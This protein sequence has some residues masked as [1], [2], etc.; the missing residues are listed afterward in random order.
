MFK[1]GVRY[2]RPGPE[3][4][5]A[6]VT[7]VCEDTHHSWDAAKALAQAGTAVSIHADRIAK[8]LDERHDRQAELAAALAG[9]GDVRA[10]PHLR[11]LAKDRP[12]PTH[13]IHVGVLA[14]LPAAGLLPTMRTVLRQGPPEYHAN[15]SALELLAQ[16][17]PDSAPAVPE[18]LPYLESPHAYD[19]LRVLGR[20][21][22][23]AAVA[24]GR[25]T[26]PPVAPRRAPGTTPGWPPGRTGGSP[27]TRSSPSACAVRPRLPG[28]RATGCPSW[29]TS[30]RLPPRTR[31][32]CAV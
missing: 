2:R 20:I 15:T 4:W 17:G 19:A 5:D 13:R 10:V 26:S 22:P 12:F 3:C 32:P 14:A 16:R 23:A 6:V 30:D 24:A 8:A 31:T 18:V 11:R 29:P 27:V 9:M 1:A 7:A 21:G 28:A 25:P